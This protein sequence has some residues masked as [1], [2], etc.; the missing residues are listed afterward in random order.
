MQRAFNALAVGILLTGLAGGC[1][2]M[3]GRTAGTTIDNKKIE[4]SVKAKLAAD[5][6]RNLTWVD[7]DANDGV[8]YLTGNAATPDDKA[9]ATEIAMRTTGV[10]RVVNDIVV[11][12]ERQAGAEA[13]PSAPAASPASG[14]APGAVTGDVVS[15]DP[16]SGNV[17]LRMPDGNTTQLRLPPASVRNVR[18][19]D[20]LSV[21]V[22]PVTR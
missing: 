14:V 12:S 1:V 9:R 20:R 7:V 22:S 10:R 6:V 13:R 3:T 17:T 2:A 5:R 11:N 19:G 16:G 8:V 18:P 21:S 4:A 15:V